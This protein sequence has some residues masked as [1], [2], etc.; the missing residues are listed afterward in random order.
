MREIQRWFGWMVLIGPVHI[1]EQLLFGIDELAEIKRVLAVYHSWFRDPDYGTV[2][3]VG[4]VVTSVM[5]MVYGLLVGGRW[6]L[7]VAGF[8]GVVGV[9]E[10]HHLV[11]TLLHLFYF[12]GTVTAIPFIA[13]GVLLLRAVVREFQGTPSPSRGG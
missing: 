1:G 13:I 9:A 5:L 11:K 4:I 8:F 2:V 7:F 6:P 3:L 10:L 12:P